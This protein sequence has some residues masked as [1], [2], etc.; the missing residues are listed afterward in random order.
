MIRKWFLKPLQ[1]SKRVKNE[2]VTKFRPEQARF[3][4]S[5]LELEIQIKQIE[6]QQ[7]LN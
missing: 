3:E 4:R 5:I 7:L 1:R 6:I 2:L